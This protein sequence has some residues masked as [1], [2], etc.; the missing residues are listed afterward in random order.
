MKN[1]I[2]MGLLML[3]ASVQSSDGVYHNMMQGLSNIMNIGEKTVSVDIPKKMAMDNW[4][5]LND[6]FGDMEALKKKRKSAPEDSWFYKTKED[7]DGKILDIVSEISV[8]LEDKSILK[9]KK[10]I[11]RFN[12]KIEQGTRKI[13]ELRIQANLSKGEDKLGLEEN[14]KEWDIA[15][16]EW[17]I[18]KEEVYGGISLRLHSY[19]LELDI[20]QI[21]VLLS[22]VDG[23]DIIKMVTTFSI[24]SEI[25]KQLS[26]SMSETKENLIVAKKYYGFHVMLLEL[27]HY[28]QNTYISRLQN[29]YIAKLDKVGKENAKL[30]VRTNKFMNGAQGNFKKIYKGNIESQRYTKK[31]ILVYR[32]ILVRDLK[33]LKSGLKKINRNYKVALNTLETVNIS[34]DLVSLMSENQKMFQE[35]MSMQIPEL[36]PFENLQMK[37]E[38]ESLSAKISAIE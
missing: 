32:D 3:S 23:E 11:S 33:K 10:M 18:L 13:S 28:I 1:V 27:Q 17:E 4:D 16:E 38:F 6:Y 15:I 34:S 19:G 8:I 36:I 2:V 7:L 35:V 25:T 20:E 12:Q 29:V 37:R 31:V 5:E 9:D 22:R 30:I 24:I 21:K 14:I 26:A